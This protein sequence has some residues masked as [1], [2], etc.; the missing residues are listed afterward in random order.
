MKVT[1]QTFLIENTMDEP[2]PAYPGDLTMSVTDQY[3]KN[4]EISQ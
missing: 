4:N 3:L 1:F 2:S